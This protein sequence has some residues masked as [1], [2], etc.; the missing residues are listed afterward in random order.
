MP[1]IMA[2]SVGG[3]PVLKR[4]YEIPKNATMKF[5]VHSKNLSMIT[6]AIPL[7][8]GTLFFFFKK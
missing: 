4:K 6:D 2:K 1:K 8:Q 5:T 3:N 7:T